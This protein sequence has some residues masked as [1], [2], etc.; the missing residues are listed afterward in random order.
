MYLGVLSL[1]DY[2]PS[3]LGWNFPMAKLE[4]ALREQ[5]LPELAIRKGTKCMPSSSVS[6]CKQTPQEYPSVASNLF[7]KKKQ[8]YLILRTMKKGSPFVLPLPWVGAAVGHVNTFH[9][10]RHPVLH[11]DS[12]EVIQPKITQISW[13]KWMVGKADAMCVGVKFLSTVWRG[14]PLKGL[15][16]GPPQNQ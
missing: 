15:V 9:L 12:G 1:G 11:K 14:E 6:I 8:T 5:K 4:Y 13:I 2:L 3:N 10:S 7:K 16:M